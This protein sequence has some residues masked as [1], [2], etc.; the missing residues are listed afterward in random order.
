MT[1][2][3]RQAR[4]RVKICCISSA[5]EARLA[6]AAGADALGFVAGRPSGSGIVDDA[7][8][9]AVADEAPP[10]VASFLLTPHLKGADIVEHLRLCG[11][12]TVQIVDHVDPAEHAVI[13]GALPLVRRVQVIHVEGPR[14]LDLIPVYEPHIHAFLLDSGKPG[15]S[16]RELGGTGRTH[17]WKVSAE[18]VR[19]SRRPVFLAGGLNA[20]NVAA[21]IAA[22]RPFGLDLCSGVRTAGHLDPAKLDAFMQAVREAG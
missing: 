4:T 21:A 10:P 14:T 19:R 9:R 12:N 3:V 7:T 2:P 13:A 15:G 6:I 22:V 1:H 8:I 5:E 17:D 11:T 18:F 20:G 16:M